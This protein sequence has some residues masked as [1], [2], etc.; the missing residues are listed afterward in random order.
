MNQTTKEKAIFAAG[1]FWGVESAFRKIPGVLDAVVGYTGG[2]IKN[3]SYEQV[4]GGGTGH[5]EA[6]EVSF[7]PDKVSYTELV[8]AF[9][10]LHDPTQW[11][12]QGPDVG[13]QYRSA[14]FVFNESQKKQATISKEVL[15]KSGK[16]EKAIVTEVRD[17]VEFYEAEEYHQRY[18][19]KKGIDP[20]CHV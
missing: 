10:N 8:S 6:I 5:V 4:C 17:A 2:H 3:P 12:R 16:Y 9:W 14:I 1:C 13:E 20:T 15:D 18:F 7:D 11:N 19:E